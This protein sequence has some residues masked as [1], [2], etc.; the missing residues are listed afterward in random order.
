MLSIGLIRALRRSVLTSELVALTFLLFL[1]P[2]PMFPSIF[3]FGMFQPILLFPSLATSIQ[4]V[5]TAD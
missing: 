4:S 1:S 3:P 5:R 2:G